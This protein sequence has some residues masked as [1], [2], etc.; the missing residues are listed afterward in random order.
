MDTIVLEAHGFN[1]TDNVLYL[2]K[3]ISMKLGKKLGVE[4]KVNLTYQYLLFL[5]D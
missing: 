4:Q 5:R 2:D 3:Q 1:V